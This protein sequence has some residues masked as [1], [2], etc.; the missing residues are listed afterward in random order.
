MLDESVDKN[1]VQRHSFPQTFMEESC[2]FCLKFW[3]LP[4]ALNWNLLLKELHDLTRHPSGSLPVSH[5]HLQHSFLVFLAE[6]ATLLFTDPELPNT[7]PCVRTELHSATLRITHR[8]SH[9][10]LHVPTVPHMDSFLTTV[11]H[12]SVSILSK[13]ETYLSYIF[14]RSYFQFTIV[15]LHLTDTWQ[16]LQN[17]EWTNEYENKQSFHSRSAHS[18]DEL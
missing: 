10:S 14:R 17:I 8:V 3:L 1:S 4:K 15:C 5:Y 13:T 9:L 12:L 16:A 6:Q 7:A 18:Y 11:L 2:H